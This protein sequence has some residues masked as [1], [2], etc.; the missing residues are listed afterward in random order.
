MT[1]DQRFASTR[2]DVLVYK[3]EPLDHDV[4]VFG[5][6]AVDLKVSTTGTDSDFDVKVIDVYPGDIPDYKRSAPPGAAAGRRG[7]PATPSRW[8]AIS[9]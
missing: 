1:E 7:Q 2:P 6:I 3:T 9:N 4:T 8:A 5:P